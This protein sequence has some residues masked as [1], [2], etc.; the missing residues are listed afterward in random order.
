M[1]IFVDGLVFG[2][3]RYHTGSIFVP[4]LLHMLGNTYAVWQRLAG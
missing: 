2:L 3:A 4:I 1:L